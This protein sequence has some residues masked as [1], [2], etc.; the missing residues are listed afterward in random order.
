MAGQ[1]VPN[2][3]RPLAI[4]WIRIFFWILF[5][6]KANPFFLLHNI[7]TWL[8][9]KSSCNWWRMAMLCAKNILAVAVYWQT[10]NV[11]FGPFLGHFLAKILF[12]GRFLWIGTPKCDFLAMFGAFLVIFGLIWALGATQTPSVQHCKLNKGVFWLSTHDANKNFGW[13]TKKWI[14]GH[15]GACS[16]NFGSLGLHRVHLYNVVNTKK[17][18]I[19]CQLVLELFCGYIGG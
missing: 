8:A 3:N 16:V 11:I 14:F 5:F 1:Q 4:N 18:S 19:G 10:E 12:W 7:H 13:G 17:S 9:F 6:Y 15:F 2:N